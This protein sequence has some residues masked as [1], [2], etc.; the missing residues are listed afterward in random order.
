MTRMA[1]PNIVEASDH[2]CMPITVDME[3]FTANVHRRVETGVVRVYEDP[4]GFEFIEQDFD[5]GTKVLMHKAQYDAIT[6]AVARSPHM[7]ACI[8]YLAGEGP[9]PGPEEKSA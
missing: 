6:R 3:T 1:P 8:L 9:D 2:R 4:D 7:Q 5:D